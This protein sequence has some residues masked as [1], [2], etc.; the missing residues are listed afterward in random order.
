MSLP[1]LELD[2]VRIDFDG[3]C[4]LESVSLSSSGDRVGLLGQG[5]FV[6]EAMAG[7]ADVRAGSFRI[8]GI[9]LEQARESSSYA[10]ARP[11]P[12]RSNVTVR[13]GLIVSALLG[14]CRSSDA[15][16]RADRALDGLGIGHLTQQKLTR[17]PKVEHYLAGLAEAALFEP[18]A[19]VVDWPIGLLDSDGWS[20]FGTAL[21]RLVQ[22][23]RWLA[24]VPGPGRLPVERAWILTLDQLLWVESGLSVEVGATTA[25][26]VRTLVVIGTTLDQLPE[27]LSEQGLV[28]QPIRL[29]SPFGE[30]RAAFVV[31]LP[32]D[33]YGRPCTEQL[34]GWCDRHSLPLLRLEPLDRGF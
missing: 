23:R 19:I 14:G 21:S 31:E 27:G 17:R 13:E 32:R 11:W 12:A 2:D 5:N 8:G 34:L 22:H 15:K 28:L 10:V 1:L 3:R 6:F 9:E 30:Q 24:W 7:A 25:E 4:V 29:A 26:R 18:E 33:E 20:R 16:Q